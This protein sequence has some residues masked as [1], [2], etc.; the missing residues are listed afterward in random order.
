[1]ANRNI[2]FDAYNEEFDGK[3][4][5]FSLKHGQL[6]VRGL[7]MFAEEDNGEEMIE[8][9]QPFIPDLSAIGRTMTVRVTTTQRPPE[10]R[11]TFLVD[12][13]TR[14]YPLG[15]VVFRK[16]STYSKVQWIELEDQVAVAP[17]PE[18][19]ECIPCPSPGVIFNLE[20]LWPVPMAP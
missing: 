5:Y 8:N 1:M 14:Y 17:S 10:L 6:V 19:D 7:G 4:A 20:V 12:G 13:V 16:D 11:E 2:N 15:G 3:P 9:Y 18:F